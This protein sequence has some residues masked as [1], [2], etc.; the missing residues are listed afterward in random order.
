MP[1]GRFITF[2]GGEGT[3]KSTQVTLFCEALRQKGISVIQTREPGGSSGAE[4]IRDLLVKG[5]PGQWTPLTEA[6]LF[7]TARLDHVEKVIKP[8]L[9]AGSWVVCDRYHD[10]TVVYSGYG[11]GVDLKILESLYT[12]IIG[13]FHPDTVILLDIDPQVGLARANARGGDE[14]RIEQK[15]LEFHQRVR[16]GY[17][18]MAHQLPGKYIIFDANQPIEE[19]HQKIMKGVPLP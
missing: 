1:P 3:G 19:L 15:G 7:I 2:E 10:S 14:T 6:L 8:A 9:D 4:K 18:T 11:H 13:D 5:D 17:L 16:Q 12:L